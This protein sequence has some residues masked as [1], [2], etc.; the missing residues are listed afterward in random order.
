MIKLYAYYLKSIQV[1]YSQVFKDPGDSIFTTSFLGSL[2][3]IFQVA[4]YN[5][6]TRMLLMNN[7]PLPERITGVLLT[8][9]L[10]TIFNYLLIKKGFVLDDIQ[11]SKLTS[12]LVFIYLFVTSVITYSIYIFVHPN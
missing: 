11:I 4:F 9:F 8:L 3:L 10:L 1:M 2:F 12:I 5:E 6:M 7:L